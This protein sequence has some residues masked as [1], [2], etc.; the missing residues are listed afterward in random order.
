MIHHS[1]LV[2]LAQSMS[3]VKPWI[4]IANGMITKLARDWR[5]A[6]M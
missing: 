6:P 5:R 2:Q 3:T 1:R 4:S